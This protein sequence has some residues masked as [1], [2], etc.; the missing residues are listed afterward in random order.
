LIA[1]SEGYRGKATAGHRARTRRLV[2][3]IRHDHAIAKSNP[4]LGVRRNL[5]VVGSDDDR[6]AEALLQI[7]KQCHE[8]LR[9]TRAQV[10]SGLISDNHLKRV[11]ERSR[12]GDTLLFATRESRREVSE[13]MLEAHLSEQLAR[14]Q[15][16]GFASGLAWNHRYSHVLI[17][18][19]GGDQV[20]LLEDE[21]DLLGT[22][23]CQDLFRLVLQGAAS[24]P[25]LTCRGN[26]ECPKELQQR[27]LSLSARSLQRNSLA[28]RDV[29]TYP[30]QRVDGHVTI[31]RGR[32]TT[33]RNVCQSA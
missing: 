9:V 26:V 23:L 2:P 18:A 8:L 25:D 15:G 10:A 17:R 29:K 33:R 19:Q 21:A 14:T 5:L 20:E 1:S 13:S 16:A 3:R 11:S 4:P 27:R 22:N 24:E 32:C 6:D 7:M 30:T 12:N 28:L 31:G